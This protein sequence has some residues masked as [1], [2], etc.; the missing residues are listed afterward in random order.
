MILE[1]DDD[2][3][4]A[5]LVRTP[6]LDWARNPVTHS[7]QRGLKAEDMTEWINSFIDDH[8]PDHLITA[9]NNVNDSP[10]AEAVA[11]SRADALLHG[12]SS[13]LPPRHVVAFGAALT[14]KINLESHIDDCSEAL[15]CVQVRRKADAIAGTPRLP[16][17][18]IWPAV[19]SAP[20]PEHE[21]L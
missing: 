13:T 11:H 15:E 16:R 19:W 9:G 4:V 14:A 20:M 17:P 12:R 3:I 10:F 18:S 1:Y 21:E 5:S 8:R 7:V 2:L 6:L